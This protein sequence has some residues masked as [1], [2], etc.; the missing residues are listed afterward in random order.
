ML[1]TV[2]SLQRVTTFL[3]LKSMMKLTR[4]G[5]SFNMLTYLPKNLSHPTMRYRDTQQPMPRWGKHNDPS[6]HGPLVRYLKNGRLTIQKES[7]ISVIDIF[8]SYMGIQQIR[9]GL[10][11]SATC[12]YDIRQGEGKKWL[13][14]TSIKSQ[15]M[16]TM[17]VELL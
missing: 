8:A 16:P 6:A 17:G 14:T 1:G 11:E 13:A 5:L 3:K 2:D 12:R 10:A 15:T 7:L 4:M 9:D